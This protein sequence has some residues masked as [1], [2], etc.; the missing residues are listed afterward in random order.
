MFVQVNVVLR[1]TLCD[2]ISI[3]YKRKSEESSVMT[4]AQDVEKA[5]NVVTNSPPQD[6]T[7]LDEYTSPACDMTPQHSNP[8]QC[9]LTDLK[10]N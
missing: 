8:L 1:W 6:C 4:S 5:V 2:D 7:H 10:A 9:S 3:T